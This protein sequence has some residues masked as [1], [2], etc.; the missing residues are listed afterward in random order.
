MK[1]K[2]GWHYIAGYYVYV[3]DG[4]IL[5]GLSHDHQKTTYVYRHIKNGW[6]CENGITIAAFQTG[7]R[8]GT[9]AMV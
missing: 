1:M 4:K 2:D 8:R 3:E 9:I 5:R 6:I 7:V